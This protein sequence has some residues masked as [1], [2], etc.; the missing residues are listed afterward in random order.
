MERDNICESRVRE[1]GMEA[2]VQLAPPRSA[3]KVRS[4]LRSTAVR[5]IVAILAL[6]LAYYGAAKLAQSLR[7]T[8]SVSAVWPPAGLGIAALY[9]WGLRLWPGIFIGEL[10]I[11]AEL[12]LGDHG[13]PFWSVVGQQAGNMLEI[14]VG[15]VLLRRLIGPKAA[16]DRADQVIGMLVALA[17]ATAISATVGTISM[18]AGGVIDESEALTFFRTWWLG[19]T[20]GGLIALPLIV[21]W[22]HDP[23]GSFRRMRTL[24]GGLL[25]G[26]VVT[27]SVVSISADEPVTYLVFPALIWA[28]LRFGPAGAT[29]S[30]AVA[31]VAAIAFTANELGPF[32]KQPIDHRALST[33][34]YV[35]VAALTTLFV[36]ALVSERQRSVSELE[37][38]RRREGERALEERHRIARDLH[39]SVS[40]ALFSTVLHTRTAEREL[41]RDRVDPRG[42]VASALGAIAQLTAGAQR[43]MRNLLFE[44]N[45]TAG[46]EG[47]VDA[48]ARHATTLGNPEG[49]TVAV[50]GPEQR[51][52][53]SPAAETQ[54]FAIGREALAN[55][56]KHSAARRA[57]VDVA[58]G[59][60]AVSLEIR[61]DGSGFD[62]QL[63]HPGH[64]GLE[65]MRTRAAEA[66]ASLT[67]VSVPGR[68]TVVRVEMPH[69]NGAN[70]DGI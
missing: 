5:R 4:F 18:L 16:L 39:D 31:A 1:D 54:L 53:I 45:G 51:L 60:E 13:I 32:A 50:R 66:G 64:Y 47:L 29:L 10:A 14:I 65:S 3:W 23:R 9:L 52:P 21:T 38:A 70:G 12:L 58:A 68:G 67:I 63:D 35:A 26:T 56:V 19:D 36:G 37:I 61:D 44:L 42:P 20:A 17:A 41:A 62:A 59:V 25:L 55:V 30:I 69:E 2:D 8:A 6:A 28:A 49:L 46:D 48:L 34:L 27:L 22:A 57:W 11:N 7:Y 43:E 40:Q 33:Q 24:E 15:A